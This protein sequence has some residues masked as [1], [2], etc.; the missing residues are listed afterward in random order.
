MENLIQS[1][2]LCSAGTARSRSGSVRRYMREVESSPNMEKNR[3]PPAGEPDFLRQPA[4]IF[5][6]Q[7]VLVTCMDPRIERAGVG[8]R[9]KK[10]GEEIERSLD[11]RW[12]AGY[13]LLFVLLYLANMKEFAFHDTPIAVYQDPEK[14][15][16]WPWPA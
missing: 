9:P 1:I 16:T 14:P 10:E 2:P 4:T 7:R 11:P 6:G 12:G 13:P 8:A 3:D 5:P 15:T